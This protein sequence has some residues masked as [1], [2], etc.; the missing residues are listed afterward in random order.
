MSR[1]R[2][3]Q[4]QMRFEGRC[5]ICGKTAAKSLRKNNSNGKSPYCSVHLVVVRERNRARG[6][7]KRRNWHAGSYKEVT[8][9]AVENSDPNDG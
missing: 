8:V 5:V 4:K 1:Q 9:D 7:R 6:K 3:Y 2:D